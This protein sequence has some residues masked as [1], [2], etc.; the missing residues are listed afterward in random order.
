MF[1]RC[2][3]CDEIIGNNF[4]YCKC[5]AYIEEEDEMEIKANLQ[6]LEVELDDLLSEGQKRK[7]NKIRKQIKELKE[8]LE[9][10]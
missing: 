5:C 9:E 10:D 8:L 6:F 7:A 2:K 1:N 3:S 4:E